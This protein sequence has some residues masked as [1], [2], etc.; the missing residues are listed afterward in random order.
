MRRGRAFVAAAFVPVALAALSSSAAA[1]EFSVTDADNQLAKLSLFVKAERVIDRGQ[2]YLLVKIQVADMRRV[3]PSGGRADTISLE[4]NGLAF[5]PMQID[6]DR[7][8]LRNNGKAYRPEA[9][10]LC[11]GP[12]KLDNARVPPLFV[13]FK[14]P[15]AGS[16]D[17]V[18]PV[19]VLPV[20]PSIAARDPDSRSHR[21]PRPAP[22]LVGE[23]TGV[24]R[25]YLDD[26]S[27]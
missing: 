23:Y 22:E 2:H 13:A 14:H 4:R 15:P 12:V 1:K 20:R 3:E 26:A 21:V 17:I 19:T 8:T 5:M 7:I 11:T 24:A 9:R 27:R 16:T 10:S 6:C 18:V 25:F